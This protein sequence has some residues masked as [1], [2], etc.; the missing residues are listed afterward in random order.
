LYK[1]DSEVPEQEYK[2]A[3]IYGILI[4]PRFSGNPVKANLLSVA[5]ARKL[6]EKNIQYYWGKIED[7]EQ[8]FRRSE[9]LRNYKKQLDKVAAAI[10]KS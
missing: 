4:Y 10:C 7:A 9:N 5:V 6:T 8:E 2:R 3:L 1:P